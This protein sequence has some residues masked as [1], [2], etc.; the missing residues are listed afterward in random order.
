MRNRM[1]DA[2]VFFSDRA[3]TVIV[4]NPE[5]VQGGWMTGLIPTSRFPKY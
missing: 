2:A 4:A 3:E 5:M 1:I